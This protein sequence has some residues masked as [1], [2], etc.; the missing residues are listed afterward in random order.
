M[1]WTY[2]GPLRSNHPRRIGHPPVRCR[3]G[4]W[5]SGNEGISLPPPHELLR[6][7]AGSLDDI[8]LGA[9]LQRLSMHRHDDLL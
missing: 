3:W 6:R 1:Y 2:R 8:H 9:A 5:A 7:Q 4:C